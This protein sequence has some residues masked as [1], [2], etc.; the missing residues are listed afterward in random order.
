MGTHMEEPP[1]PMSNYLTSVHPICKGQY[2]DRY[3]IHLIPLLILVS[4]GD[5][6]VYGYGIMCNNNDYS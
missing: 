2:C 6:A 4:H 1:T 5:S 3:P